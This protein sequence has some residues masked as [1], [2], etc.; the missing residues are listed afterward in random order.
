[1]SAE[2]IDR[3][4]DAV[5]RVASDAGARPPMDCVDCGSPIPSQTRNGLRRARC[6]ECNRKLRAERTKRW[7]ERKIAEGKT[8]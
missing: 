7:L 3:A 4:I 2:A 5:H 6:A 8:P 1:M